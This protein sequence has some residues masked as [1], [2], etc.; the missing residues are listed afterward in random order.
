MNRPEYI[1]HWFEK[2]TSSNDK[3]ET[4]DFK[5]LLNNF[6]KI[7]RLNKRY[8]SFLDITGYA[9]HENLISNVFKFLLQPNE[10]H[11]FKDL[12]LKSLL[13]CLNLDIDYKNI[14]VNNIFREF[15][16]SKNKRIDLVIETRDL[17]IGIENKVYADLY[18][19]LPNY[20]AYLKECFDNKKCIL[21][22]LSLSKIV[23]SKLRGYNNITY[24][25]IITKVNREK[26]KY[27]N[28]ENL[29]TKQ[30][31][32]FNSTIENMAN[33]NSLNPDFV[34]LCEKD[35]ALINNFM[36]QL[37][38]QTDTVTKL[39][40]RI[41]DILKADYKE[42]PN[43]WRNFVIYRDFVTKSG[44][45]ISIDV[46]FNLIGIEINVWIREPKNRSIDRLRDYGLKF[47]SSDVIENRVIL[48]KAESMS[49]LTDVNKIIEEIKSTY[50]KIESRIL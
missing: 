19:D 33:Y 39:V 13:N 31:E 17:V 42:L 50:Q 7:E 6:S 30:I 2:R 27:I 4:N 24:N 12:Y 16:T 44:D 35:H 28:Q 8:R 15:S 11:G 26:S 14:E 23:R 34:K 43:P 9:H 3:L 1:D 5:K 40:F 47:D 21:I 45:V 41:H 29:Y 22:V 10:E 36:K 46:L 38:N 18:N 49:I 20:E 37:Q 25:Q 48:Q 32:D